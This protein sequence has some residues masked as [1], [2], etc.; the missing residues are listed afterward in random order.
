MPALRSPDPVAPRARQLDLFDR[1]PIVEVLDPRAHVGDRSR[2]QTLCRVAF[3]IPPSTHLVFHDRHGW[4]CS[5]HGPHCEAV[6]VARRG[7]RSS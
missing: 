5:Q 3:A 1:P 4:Y 6:E 7:M 2:V